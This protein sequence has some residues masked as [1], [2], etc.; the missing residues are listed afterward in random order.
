[1]FFKAIM[2]FNK[3]KQP[4]KIEIFQHNRKDFVS[5]FSMLLRKTQT[6]TNRWQK[7]T[8]IGGK[9]DKNNISRGLF[10]NFQK[11]IL[12]RNGKTLGSED[13]GFGILF[14]SIRFGYNLFGIFDFKIITH[15]DDAAQRVS[16]CFDLACSLFHFCS[17][18]DRS[19]EH[20]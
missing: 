4:G 6:R 2:R 19:E 7:R 18:E 15:K 5:T 10:E 17:D 1:M 13:K 3:G 12:G 9:E 11:G 20:T 16:R 14:A 8:F